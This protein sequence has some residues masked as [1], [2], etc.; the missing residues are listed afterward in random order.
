MCRLQPADEEFALE[1]HLGGEMVVQGD[2]QFFL[3]HDFALPCV[4]IHLQK[5]IE[6]GAQFG[7]GLSMP[8]Q[9][10]SSK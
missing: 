2:E 4:G 9:F 6:G 8:F 5:L 1:D 7:S 3:V 10:M